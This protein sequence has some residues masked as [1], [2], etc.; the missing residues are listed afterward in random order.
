MIVSF[1]D[2][3]HRHYHCVCYCNEIIMMIIV[4]SLLLS[5]YL[6]LSF[7]IDCLPFIITIIIRI[8]III[9]IT[10]L[11]LSS[12]VY[13]HQFISHRQ[14]TIMTIILVTMTITTIMTIIIVTIPYHPQ[15]YR[16]GAAATPPPT[17]PPNF[18]ENQPIR[19]KMVNF[20]IWAKS[21]YQAGQKIVYGS[22]AIGFHSCMYL[23]CNS[24]D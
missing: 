24:A 3:Y 10:S 17:P 12:P 13:Y 5:L 20:V 11:S 18:S 15:A 16:L 14:V 6:S 2:Q 21:S 23:N 4:Y 1:L 8:I 22:I 19:A 9:I 7:I